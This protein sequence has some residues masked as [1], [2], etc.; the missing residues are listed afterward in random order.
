MR[1][2]DE[3]R[4]DGVATVPVADACLH[5][6]QV[7]AEHCPPPSHNHNCCPLTRVYKVTGSCLRVAIAVTAQ[8]VSISLKTRGVWGEAPRF[9]CAQ[10][11][12]FFLVYL[13][14]D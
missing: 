13:L 6:Q 7:T 4:A 10:R 14:L 12:F 8:R 5:S 3:I 9:P 11:T 2:V 1:C